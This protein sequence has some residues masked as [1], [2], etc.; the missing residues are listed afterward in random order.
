MDL[1]CFCCFNYRLKCRVFCRLDCRINGRI[2]G[3]ANGCVVDAVSCRFNFYANPGD[4]RSPV[5]LTELK[6]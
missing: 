2:N 5:L 4:L 6:G 1:R 3:R